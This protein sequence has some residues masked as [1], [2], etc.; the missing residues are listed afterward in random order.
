MAERLEIPKDISPKDFFE[1]FVP[2]QF[3][4]NKGM[5]P[6][7]VKAVSA[8]MVFNLT[9][10]QGGAWTIRLD[11]G[12]LRVSEGDDPDRTVKVIQSVSDW[13]GAISGERGFRLDLPGAGGGAG[14][15]MPQGSPMTQDKIERLKTIEGAIMFRLTDKEKGDWAIT[16]QFGKS[17]KETP[18]CTISMSGDDAKAMRK[19]NLNPQMAFMSG[20][21]DIKGDLGFA[22]QVGTTFMM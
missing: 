12:N 6:E 20:K 1:K 21:I 11:K 14:A 22:M 15:G 13:R 9:G 18:D 2:E 5:L 8:S 17:A 19:G 16:V 3:E 7:P 10:D 4:K